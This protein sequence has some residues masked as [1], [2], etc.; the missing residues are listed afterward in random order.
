MAKR[1][2]YPRQHIFPHTMLNLHLTKTSHHPCFLKTLHLGL[3]TASHN[4]IFLGTSHPFRSILLYPEHLPEV[5]LSSLTSRIQGRSLH[6][7]ANF[8][9]KDFTVLVYPSHSN[10]CI[11]F[12]SNN[13]SSSAM[14]RILQPA[15]LQQ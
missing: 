8:N 14:N 15:G 10:R 11:Q 2:W 12:I 3:L 5:C 6:T 4:P 9:I 1:G 7:A 13:L